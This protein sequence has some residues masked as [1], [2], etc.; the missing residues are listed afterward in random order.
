MEGNIKKINPGNQSCGKMYNEWINEQKEWMKECETER[1]DPKWLGDWDREND[2]REETSTLKMDIKLRNEGVSNEKLVE[3]LKKKIEVFC[4]GMNTSFQIL[5][6]TSCKVL[7]FSPG[8]ACSFSLQLDPHGWRA[9]AG[10]RASNCGAREKQQPGKYKK[11]HRIAEKQPKILST[12]KGPPIK[13]KTLNLIFSYIIFTCV[14][15]N[16]FSSWILII[17]RIN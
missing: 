16:M 15:I 4:E 8:S 2:H 11:N 6:K 13:M 12:L 17:R 5:I 1:K 7:K 10:R 14:K 9:L 3:G